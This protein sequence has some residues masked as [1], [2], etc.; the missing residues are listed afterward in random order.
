LIFNSQ[1]RPANCNPIVT[2][3]TQAGNKSWTMCELDAC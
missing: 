1:S 3:L 2:G